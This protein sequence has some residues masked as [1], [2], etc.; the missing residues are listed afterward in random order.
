[1]CNFGI[2]DEKALLIS[3]LIKVAYN[4]DKKMLDDVN[5]FKITAN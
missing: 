1:M 3:F 5:I 4:E 2:T